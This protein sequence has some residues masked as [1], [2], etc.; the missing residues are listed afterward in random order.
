MA[1]AIKA[2]MRNRLFHLST[3]NKADTPSPSDRSPSP[4]AQLSSAAL[5]LLVVSSAVAYRQQPAFADRSKS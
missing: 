4:L 2:Q 3:V 5:F 1:S